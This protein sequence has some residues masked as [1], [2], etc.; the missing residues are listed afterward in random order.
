VRRAFWLHC[1]KLCRKVL[2]DIIESQV[3]LTSTKQF[4][5]LFTNGVFHTLPSTK[6]C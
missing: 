1:P 3:S 6:I 4:D 5:D 2:E